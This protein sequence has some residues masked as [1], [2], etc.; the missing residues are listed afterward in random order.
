MNKTGVTS[1]S[2]VVVAVGTRP[3]NRSAHNE[4]NPLIKRT[5][6]CSRAADSHHFRTSRQRRTA[7]PEGSRALTRYEATAEPAGTSGSRP[8]E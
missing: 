5:L 8:R 1:E 6:T 3:P 4:R 7:A 2:S